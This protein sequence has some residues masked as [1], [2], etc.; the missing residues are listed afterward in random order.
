MLLAA[1]FFHFGST[2]DLPHDWRQCDTAYYIWDFYHHGINPLEPAVCWMGGYER[3][4]LEF[5]LPEAA[6]ALLYQLTGASIPVA[7]LFFLACFAGAVFYF[8]RIVKLLWGEKL[9]QWASLIYLSLPLAWYYSRAIHIDFSAIA[10]AHAMLFYYLRGVGERRNV[11]LVKAV[12]AA[13]LAFLIK[14]PYAFYL[15]LPMLVFTWYAGALRWVLLRSWW[16]LLPLG[17]FAF[18]QQ[19][20]H[21]VNSA[22]PDWDFLPHY[23]KF[24]DNAAWYFGHWSRRLQWVP[25]KIL[26]KRSV[27][28]AAGPGTLLLLVLG[29]RKRIPRAPLFWSWV[30]GVVVYVL[31]FFNLNI[32]HNYY[33]LPLL[34]SIAILGAWGLTQWSASIPKLVPLA[35]GLGLV[36]NI[37]FAEREYFTRVPDL[38]EIGWL[39]QQQTQEEDLVVVSYGKMDCRNPR[40]LYRAR[41]RG[42]SLEVAG[43][44]REVLERLRREEGARVWAYV[45]TALPAAVGSW[46]LPE[47]QVFK[48]ENSAE[49]LFL[50]SLADWNHE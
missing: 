7:R 50:F 42:W 33:Q 25:W 41:R 14:V 28:E 5:P 2:I 19:Y 38:I 6:V 44:Q 49:S 23:R 9:A 16:W 20:V 43:L 36:F 34:A 15:A 39:I 47:A 37:T 26:L 10:A 4:I 13:T 1:R 31:I 40:I 27:L 3:V 24:D 29:L 8:Y 48:L 18:W 45:G 35:L 11:D 17:T 46:G 32:I 12:L 30:L 22:A 21:A